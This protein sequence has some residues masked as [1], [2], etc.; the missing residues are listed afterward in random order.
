[1]RPNGRRYL[2]AVGLTLPLLIYAIAELLGA[3]QWGVFLAPLSALMACAVLAHAAMHTPRGEPF[4]MA[5]WLLAA[6]CL[7]AGVT[8]GL[9]SLWV[10]AEVEPIAAG[11]RAG[12]AR[13]AGH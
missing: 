13:M 8:D 12:R 9:W 2:P 6:A 5:F 11:E 3:T 1:M 7:S 10:G 4:R